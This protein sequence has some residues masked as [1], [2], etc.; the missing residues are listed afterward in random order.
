MNFFDTEF[1]EVVE[2]MSY[3]ESVDFS[4]VRLCKISTNELLLLGCHEDWNCCYVQKLRCSSGPRIAEFDD[5]VISSFTPTNLCDA[6]FSRYED[7]QVL[8]VAEKHSIHAFDLWNVNS[9]DICPVSIAAGNRRGHLFV[10]DSPH[11]T[12]KMFSLTDGK[13]LGRV[14][15]EGEHCFG[16]RFGIKWCS[17]TS[18]LIL[19]H[20]KDNK[21]F[22]TALKIS[23]N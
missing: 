14:L 9:K 18:S 12:V 8:I 13:Y 17:R 3:S 2:E 21:L 6:C 16:Y 1:L 19:K 15:T 4:P 11:G 7:L 20:V 10:F 22:I 5:M 23:T